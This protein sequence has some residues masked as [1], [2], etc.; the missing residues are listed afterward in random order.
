MLVSLNDPIINLP[1][2][3]LT[4][5][6]E[7]SAYKKPSPTRPALVFSM[8]L[9]GVIHF[10]FSYTHCLEGGLLS[11]YLLYISLHS[12][13]ETLSGLGWSIDSTSDTANFNLLVIIDLS[14]WDLLCS[15]ST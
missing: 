11:F 15:L 14:M 6:D 5:I 7:K 4:K 12:R 8:A 13:M 2:K 3:Q 1:L 9:I 10:V